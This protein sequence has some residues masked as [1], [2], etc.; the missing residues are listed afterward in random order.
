MTQQ[1]FDHIAKDYDHDFTFSEV[2]K[3][4]RNQVYSFLNETIPNWK[5]KKVLELNA[6]TGEDAIYLAKKGA[7]VT[8]TDISMEMVKTGQEKANKT[9]LPI[10]FEQLSITQ[11]HQY[12]NDDKVAVI[13]S[14]FGGL[15][16]V[17]PAE[18]Q[19]FLDSAYQKLNDDGKLVMVIMP[20][21]CYWEFAYFF[22]KLKWKK[23]FRRLAKK[24]VMANVDGKPVPTWY[25]SPKQLKKWNKNF[26][27][28]TIK[29][30]GFFIPP[31]YLNNY[32]NRKPKL[33][34]R[35]IKWERKIE[36]SRFCAARADHYFV[37][38]NKN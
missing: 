13:F 1:D 19:S 33:L 18:F 38:L 4:Q 25:Y 30:V 31:S 24:P 29:P 22:F 10:V 27:I 8:A 7:S 37:V 34:N 2:G 21:F 36:H 16:C 9:N 14:N 32:F 15:N 28:D 11:L 3:A 5:S 35:L 26:V 23:A 20:R 12:K 17:S 6:G